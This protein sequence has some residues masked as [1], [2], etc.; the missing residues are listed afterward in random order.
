M[1]FVSVNLESEA[2]VCGGRVSK[3]STASTPLIAEVEAV[4]SMPL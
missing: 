4:E 3:E 2:P 1:L